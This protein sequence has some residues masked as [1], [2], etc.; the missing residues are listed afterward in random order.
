[1][2]ENDSIDT[3]TS[4]MLAM[5]KGKLKGQIKDFFKPEQSDEDVY[6]A[7]EIQTITPAQLVTSAVADDSDSS[8]VECDPS[9]TLNNTNVATQLAK[10]DAYIYKVSPHFND[11][12]L[13]EKREGVVWKSFYWKHKKRQLL[14]TLSQSGVDMNLFQALVTRFTSTR[15]GT[16]KKL[17]EQGD[18][19]K[20]EHLFS[21]YL[22]TYSKKNEPMV[23]LLNRLDILDILAVGMK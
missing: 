21:E 14:K 15:K 23:A 16:L 11:F 8:R 22:K 20:I 1:M 19:D 6:L 10:I 13:P 3:K 5:L 18:V 9:L 4:N 12:I 2:D 17:F 7:K